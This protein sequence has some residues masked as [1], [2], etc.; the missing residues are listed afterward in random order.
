MKKLSF[1]V[2]VAIATAAF[3]SC[4]N[5]TPKAD[6]NDDLD[7]LS[8]AIGMAQSD[9][10]KEYLSERL[11]IDTTYLDEFVKGFNEGVAAG[12]DKKKAAY[13]TGLQIGQNISTQMV[14]GINH[15]LFGEDS[16]KTI[17]V[18]N[19]IA[20]FVAGVTGEKRLMAMEQAQM[21]T[22]LKMQQIKKKQIETQFADY[23]K[24]NEEWLAKNSKN[25]GVVVLPSGLQYKI[26]TTGTGDMPADTSVVKVHYEGKTIDGKVFDSS[27]KRGEP[28]QFRVDQVIKGWTEAMKMMPVGSKWELY[29]PASLAYGEHQQGPDIKPF[30]TLIFTVELLGIGKDD[31]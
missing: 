1:A 11:G 8:Y 4:G 9:G 30:S 28:A 15:E 27:I 25:E 12:E 17:S 26:I 10:C 19:L 5:G 13:I 14:T 3:T 24:K 31:K 23:K 2:I 6:L 21:T 20:G 16:T 22:Q 7:T 18:K 29:I